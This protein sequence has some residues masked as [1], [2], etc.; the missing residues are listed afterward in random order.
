MKPEASLELLQPC[1]INIAFSFPFVHPLLENTC[2][3]D[4]PPPPL[5][6][7][8]T[9]ERFPARIPVLCPAFIRSLWPEVPNKSRKEDTEAQRLHIFVCFCGCGSD[10]VGR[11]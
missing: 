11:S 8:L 9:L 5:P 10:E 2:W 4:P 1:W 3:G 6:S 7:N